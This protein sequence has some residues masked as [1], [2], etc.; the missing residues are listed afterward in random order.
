MCGSYG[1]GGYLA[2][3]DR[4]IRLDPLDEREN[5][6][7]IAEWVREWSGKAN[8]TRAGGANLNPIIIPSRGTSRALAFAWWWLH[9][10]GKPAPFTAFNSRDDAL[11]TKWHSSFQRRALLPATWYSEGGKTWRLPDDR[12]FAIAAIT[13]PREL[14][15]GGSG[16]SYSMVTRHGVG[17]AASVVSARGESRMPLILPREAH[18]TWLDPARSGDADLITEMQQASDAIS[19]EVTAEGSTTTADAPGAAT[20]F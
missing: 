15:D 6:E 2:D 8:T 20:L 4:P 17:E 13:S 16:L 10:D 5:R 19:R 12:A 7:R 18:D 11:V 14:D 1:L 3:K 9:I